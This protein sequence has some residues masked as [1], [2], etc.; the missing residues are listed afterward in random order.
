MSKTSLLRPTP[1]YLCDELD[2]TCVNRIEKQMRV[3]PQV[4]LGH[5]SKDTAHVR[6]DTSYLF[7]LIAS[8]VDSDFTGNVKIHPTILGL[9]KFN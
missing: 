1:L 8:C 2:A 3:H 4:W 7:L 9:N 6:I 5:R